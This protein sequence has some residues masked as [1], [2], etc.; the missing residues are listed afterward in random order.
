MLNKHAGGHRMN[1]GR[2]PTVYHWPVIMSI[3]VTTKLA[4]LI[5]HSD[6]LLS[7]EQVAR[8]FENGRKVASLTTS[9]CPRKVDKHI[10]LQNSMW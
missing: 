5:S 1:G 6:T 10:P 4:V 3:S 2:V 9:A 7:A 8:V